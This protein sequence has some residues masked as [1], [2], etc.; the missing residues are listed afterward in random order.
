ME[1]IK[2][3]KGISL[4]DIL[5]KLWDNRKLVVILTLIITTVLVIPL[6]FMNKPSR[7]VNVGFEYNFIGVE[8]NRYP[9][10]T[11]F[12]FRSI[13][14]FALL[15]EVASSDAKFSKIDVLELFLDED[16]RIRRQEDVLSSDREIIF[17]RNR[18]H[19]TMPLKYFSYDED[20]A[21]EFVTLLLNK[22]LAYAIDSYSSLELIN[23]VDFVDD[24]VDY[25]ESIQY[26]DTQYKLLVANYE[27]FLLDN[28][29]VK[30]NNIT[31]ADQYLSFKDRFNKL[32]SLEEL[33]LLVKQEKY[34][35]N[36]TNFETMTVLRINVINEKLDLN[37][38][39][40]ASLENMF[41]TLVAPSNLQQAEELLSNIIQLR[42][43]NIDL[44][45]L[46]TDLQDML[47]FIGTQ[48]GDTFSTSTFLD[49]IDAYENLLSDY[50]DQYNEFQTW[51][52]HNQTT[53]IYDNGAV[54]V[55]DGGFGNIVIGLIS[56][57]F[58]FAFTVAVV[59]VKDGFKDSKLHQAL[60]KITQNGNNAS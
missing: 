22:P 50:T 13:L 1:N 45:K 20:L 60:Q 37:N 4:I 42:L 19:L 15:D 17:S 33:E 29:N 54:V 30:M 39:K 12:D 2:E 53:L 32:S 23:N 46:R 28:G 41:N 56:G 59:L 40:I 58:A 8:E 9:D 36:F 52:Y 6:Y 10:G 16:T 5:Q 26:Y 47:D 21:K 44:T 18:Y 48:S 55:I 27:K 31:I 57:M 35:K 43:E 14:S 3:E 49:K 34:I 7:L 24:N 11:L 38:L 25:I 51:F